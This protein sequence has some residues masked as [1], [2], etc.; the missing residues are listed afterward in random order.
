[1][2]TFVGNQ[3]TFGEALKELVELEYA[4]VEAYVAAIDRLDNIDYKQKLKAFQS[5]HE[6]HIKEVSDVLDR[7]NEAPPQGPNLGKELIT[8]GK[9]ILTN[10]VGDRT[11][12]R[13][14]RSNE[15]DTNTAYECMNARED[16]WPEA[17]DVLK[18]GL[19]DEVKH[20]AW[21]TQILLER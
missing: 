12:L 6:R 17:R 13:A 11:I 20:K 15:E 8:K 7:K 4:A 9:V 16:I 14:M 10:M 5:E 2:V 19:R 1:M 21:L 3:G 18:K